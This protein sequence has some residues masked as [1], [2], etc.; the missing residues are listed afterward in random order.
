LVEQFVGSM[1]V[2]GFALPLAAAQPVRYAAPI[3]NQVGM[4]ADIV[5]RTAQTP[6]GE[7]QELRLDVYEPAPDTERSRPAILWLHGSGMNRKQNY[8]V[9]LATEFAMRG[10]V[11]VASDYRRDEAAVPRGRMLQDGIEDA[12]AALTWV[13]SHTQEYGIDPRHIALGGGSAGGVIA[14]NVIEATNEDAAR[15][16]T[17]EI[18]AFVD[19]WGSPSAPYLKAPIGRH[20]PPTIIIHGTADQSVPFRNSEILDARLAELGITHKLLPLPGARHTPI[21]QIDLIVRASAQFIYEQLG[22]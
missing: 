21:D 8:I 14:W 20:F 6:A 15:T 3:F 22:R 2:A 7:R 11:C 18:F 19:L 4:T 17:P 12:Q 10:Y 1:V 9:R 16:G 5:L 13:R